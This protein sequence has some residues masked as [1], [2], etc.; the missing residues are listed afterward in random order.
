MPD[1]KFIAEQKLRLSKANF[2]MGKSPAVY[3]STNVDHHPA[4][5]TDYQDK[6][7]RLQAQHKNQ[8]TNFIHHSGFE[9]QTSNGEYGP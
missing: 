7:Q 5:A 4:K 9:K 6:A 3:T 8:K 1:P 2:S